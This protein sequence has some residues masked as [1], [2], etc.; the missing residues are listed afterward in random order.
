[1]E[2]DKGAPV[3]WEDTAASPWPLACSRCRASGWAPPWSGH[4]A[5]LPADGRAPTLRPHCSGLPM[6]WEWGELPPNTPLAPLELP[7]TCAST[8]QREMEVLPS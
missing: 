3:P 8:C 6:G 2:G 4:R 7:H 1:M 5:H